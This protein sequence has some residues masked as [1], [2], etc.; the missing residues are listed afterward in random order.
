MIKNKKILFQKRNKQ[1]KKKKRAPKI[2]FRNKKNRCYYFLYLKIIFI[3]ILSILYNIIGNNRK[4]IPS[5]CL[6]VIG[7]RENLYAKEYVNHY[8]QLGYSHIYIYDN[9]DINDEKFEDVLQDEIKSNFVSII[10][11]R[12]IIGPQ[13]HIYEECYEKNNKNYDWLSFFDFDEFLDVSPYANNIQE[14]LSNKRYENCTTLKINFLF[15]SDNELLYYDNRTLKERFT[16]ALPGHSSN[17]VI[18]SIVRGGLHPNYW[19]LQ[20]N[21][22]TSL[23]KCNSCNSAGESVDYKAMS[24]SPTHKYARL[25]HYYTKSTEEYANKAKRGEVFGLANWD[26]KRK[27][28]KYDLYY[29]YNKKTKEK[30]ELLRKV[31]D[32]TL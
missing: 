31:L 3:T 21:A 22:H 5:I 18:K 4:K 20:F 9:N 25:N 23:F 10:N 1:F 8:K 14:F 17:S 27:K 7:K 12:G 2:F 11:Y 24:F 28:F 6:C 32:I 16:T 19:S 15:Y 13:Y 30:D 29:Y 26:E